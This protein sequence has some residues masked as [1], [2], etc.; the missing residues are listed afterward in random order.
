MRGSATS[1][2]PATGPSDNGS[3]SLIAVH[4]TDTYTGTISVNAGGVVAISNAQPVGTHTITIRATDNCGAT[5]DATFDLQVDNTAPG[6][7]PSGAKSRQQ[8]SDSGAAVTVG[9]VSDAE[10]ADGDLLVT[11]IGGGSATGITVDS[12]S[13]TTGTVTATLAASCTSTTGTVR[14]QVSDGDLTG[15]GDLQVDIVPDTPPTLGVYANT[16]VV[17]GQGVLISP[18]VEPAD[19]GNVDGVEV[20]ILPANFTGSLNA[21]PDTAEIS[22]GEAAPLGAYTI[23]VTVTDN[24][25][26]T[27]ERD[28]ALEVVEDGIFT[29]GFETP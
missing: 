20:G 4:D 5:T 25:G 11:Q 22:V 26:T 8:G 7:T 16:A 27:A 9:T 19:N 23:S 17:I 14:F 15:N 2:N 29:D 21:D 10:S 18:D 1:V 12:I 24:C 3:V 28:I 13:N 6:F